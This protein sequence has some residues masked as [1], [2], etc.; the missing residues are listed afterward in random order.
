MKLDEAKMMRMKFDYTNEIMDEV[1]D[2]NNSH[3]V[4]IA[5]IY[6]RK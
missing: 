4:G 6:E 3:G 5:N 1:G 2:A